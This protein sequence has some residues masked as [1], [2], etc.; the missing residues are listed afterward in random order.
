MKEHPED[1]HM[2]IEY[3]LHAFKCMA[4]NC[5][6]KSPTWLE[7]NHSS[8]KYGCFV[9]DCPLLKQAKEVEPV[10]VWEV[11]RRGHRHLPDLL[12]TDCGNLYPVKCIDAKSADRICRHC[13]NP[14]EY[15]EVTE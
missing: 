13:G 11:R 3:V 1:F 4:E 9:N 6:Y 14:V 12:A 7:C 5:D 15:R 10:C 8:N 2:R